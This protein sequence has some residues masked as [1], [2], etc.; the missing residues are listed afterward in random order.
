MLSFMK[1]CAGFVEPCNPTYIFDLQVKVRTYIARCP[2]FVT[3]QNAL[4]FTPWWNYSF[5]CHLEFYGRHSA[6]LQLLC[7]NCSFTHQPLSVANHDLIKL[8][9]LWQCG[10]SDLSVQ[11]GPF[12]DALCQRITLLSMTQGSRNSKP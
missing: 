7:E 1:L 8:S 5:K 10:P 11:V 2:V 9:K 3:A 6:I 4:Y 12:L